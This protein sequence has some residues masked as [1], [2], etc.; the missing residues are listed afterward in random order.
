MDGMGRVIGVWLDTM[1]CLAG[2]SAAFQDPFFIPS[3]LMPSSY[4]CSLSGEGD[5]I[6]KFW[7]LGHKQTF[8]MCFTGSLPVSA[9]WSSVGMPMGLEPDCEGGAVPLARQGRVRSWKRHGPSDSGNGHSALDCF[10]P[11]FLKWE[12]IKFYLTQATMI[13]LRYVEPHL[14]LTNTG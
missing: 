5:C 6:P 12:R 3:S 1:R 14:I 8:S 13:F 11:D 2:L 7:T 4:P 9:L 10:P